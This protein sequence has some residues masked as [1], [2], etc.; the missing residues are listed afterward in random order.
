MRS[1]C[2]AQ[3]RPFLSYPFTKTF[4]IKFKFITSEVPGGYFGS[5]F[6][7]HFILTIRSDT[8]PLATMINSMNALGLGA[9]DSNGATDW[10]Q[11]TLS[12]PSNCKSAQFDIGVSNVA[13]SLLNSQIIVDKAGDLTCDQRGDC[14]ACPGDPMCSDTCQMAQVGSCAFY[15]DCVEA[16]VPCLGT[17]D[18]YAINYGT[19]NCNAY[20]NNM[21][22]FSSKGQSFI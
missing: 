11:L 19:K 15:K 9:F 16:S 12:V 5:Q 6:N 4:Y 2:R 3:L 17:P 7:D 20:K 8:G 18:S 1:P 21:N 13:D 10:M 14:N 22:L